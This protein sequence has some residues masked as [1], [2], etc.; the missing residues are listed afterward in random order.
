VIGAAKPFQA[1]IRA[2]WPAEA[3]RRPGGVNASVLGPSF[4]LSVFSPESPNPANACLD[5][6]SLATTQK[7][8]DPRETKR[9]I[10]AMKLLTA[11]A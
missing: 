5:H 9:Q 8:F 1:G 11:A 6:A 4:H 10:E 7:Y 2:I 3:E